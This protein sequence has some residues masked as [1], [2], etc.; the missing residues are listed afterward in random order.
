MLAE[1]YLQDRIII[2]W[3]GQARR[4]SASDVASPEGKNQKESFRAGQ[5]ASY[6][7]LL[8]VS[9]PC[10]LFCSGPSSCT[11]GQGK[12][13][14]R[15]ASVR[16]SRFSF[17]SFLQIA[18]GRFGQAF[19]ELIRG[20]PTS[21]TRGRLCFRSASQSFFY[22]AARAWSDSFSAGS[23]F[24]HQSDAVWAWW[25]Y[26]RKDSLPIQ[27]GGGPKKARQLP[28]RSFPCSIFPPI[29]LF[30]IYP[31]LLLHFSLSS[32]LLPSSH[33]PNSHIFIAQHVSK[34]HCRLCRRPFRPGGSFS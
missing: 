17:F 31:L 33:T 12:S 16:Q 10:L 30:L 1:K 2:L 25:T 3:W 15:L 18:W 20:A 21:A 34:Q 14:R 8:S 5:L 27:T 13:S 6:S 23:L 26:T 29:F 22:Y 32:P 11:S 9:A 19:L 28:L 24:V 4:S 7:F